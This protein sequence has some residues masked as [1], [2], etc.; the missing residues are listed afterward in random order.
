MLDDVVARQFLLGQ[1]PPEEQG[2]IEELAFEDRDTFAFLESAED[3]LIDEFIQ[4]DLS[5]DEEQQFKSHFLS[6]PGR[7]TNLEI[8]RLLQLHF[9]RAAPVK[10]RFSLVRWFREQNIW[11]QIPVTAAA[12][13]GLAIFA[14]L[15]SN[16]IRPRQSEPIQAGS[17]RPV[18]IPSPSVE[19]SP[20]HIPT[21]SPAHTENKPKGATPERQKRATAYALLSPS[22][23]VRSEGVQELKLPS[24]VPSVT[25]ELA[26]ITRRNFSSFEVAL[27][28]DPGKVLQRW[29]DLKAERLRSGKALQIEVPVALLKSGDLYRF[30]VSGVSVKAEPEVVARYPFAVQE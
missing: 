5:A 27:E 20:S 16:R 26:L 3:D 25:V 15:V 12:A 14:L 18:V 10:K 28:N 13:V 2:R 8:S 9:N 21:P 7:R 22:S 29:P 6:Q 1:L 17:E 4:G 30:V 19:I 11:L 23:A 24:D